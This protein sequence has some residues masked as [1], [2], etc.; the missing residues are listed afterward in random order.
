M[1]GKQRQ[2][3]GREWRP[4]GERQL[5][6]SSH[7]DRARGHERGLLAGERQRRRQQ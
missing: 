3:L 5:G 1:G 7:A 2:R 4:M 6:R